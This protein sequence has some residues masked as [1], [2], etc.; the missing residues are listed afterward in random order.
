MLLLSPFFFDKRVFF[1]LSR[2]YLGKSSSLLICLIGY[3]SKRFAHIYT[4]VL[5][6]VVAGRNEGIRTHLCLSRARA[7][8]P[9]QRRC[10]KR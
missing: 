9:G 1:E 10:Q 2:A 8:A 6:F 3:L 5:L 4:G 7:R